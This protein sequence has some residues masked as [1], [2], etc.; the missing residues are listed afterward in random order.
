MHATKMWSYKYIYIHIN[1]LYISLVKTLRLLFQLF[2]HNL[3]TSNINITLVFI[4]NNR[5]FIH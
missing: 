2:A 5:S 4:I 3:K 1:Y